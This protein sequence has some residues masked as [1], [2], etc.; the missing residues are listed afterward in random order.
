MAFRDVVAPNKDVVLPRQRDCRASP[1][2]FGS[3]EGLCLLMVRVELR[4]QMMCIVCCRLL[5]VTSPH[6]LLRASS[7]RHGQLHE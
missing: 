7:S 6:I 5:R 4:C 3:Q 2:L 1:R